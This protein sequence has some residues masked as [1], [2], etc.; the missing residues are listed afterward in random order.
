[1]SKRAEQRALEAYPQ[2]IDYYPKIPLSTVPAMRF[3][4]EPLC[5]VKV[6]EDGKD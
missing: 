3:G 5:T 6:V 4:S 2:S 1:M